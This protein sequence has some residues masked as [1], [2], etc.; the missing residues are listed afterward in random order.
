M[1]GLIFYMNKVKKSISVSNKNF[2]KIRD[3]IYQH[4]IAFIN[5]DENFIRSQIRYSL[6]HRIYLQTYSTFESVE[7]YMHNTAYDK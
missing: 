4:T 1:G 3:L 2:D 7:S 6:C 5:D